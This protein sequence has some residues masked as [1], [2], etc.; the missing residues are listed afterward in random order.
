MKVGALAERPTAAVG[1]DVKKYVGAAGL[2]AFVSTMLIVLLLA[3]AGMLRP[4]RSPIVPQT[5]VQ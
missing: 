1:P 2:L 3:S 5:V 4:S